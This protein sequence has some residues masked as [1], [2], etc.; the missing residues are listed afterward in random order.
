MNLVR[1]A[2]IIF[3]IAFAVWVIFNITIW[4][5]EFKR[6]FFY[7]DDWVSYIMLFA[8][9]MVIGWFIRWLVVK[10]AVMTRPGRRR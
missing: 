8:L 6:A 2:L 4:A 5:E 3:S 7:H 9:V 10:G 1:A